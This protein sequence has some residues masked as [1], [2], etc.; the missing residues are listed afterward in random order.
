MTPTA[1]V[2]F[3]TIEPG[4]LIDVG[5]DRLSG[6]VPAVGDVILCDDGESQQAS[7][8]LVAV[9]GDRLTMRLDMTSFV[10]TLP[11]PNDDR[12]HGENP[13]SHQHRAAGSARGGGSRG[14][15]QVFDQPGSVR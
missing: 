7:A 2:D 9:E 6:G 15:R 10:F 11:W 1:V 8:V 12:L 3:N 14:T 13:A 4:D 5:A